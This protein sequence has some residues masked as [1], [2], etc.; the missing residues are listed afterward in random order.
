MAKIRNTLAV[1]VLSLVLLI[2]PQQNTL[3]MRL[4]TTYQEAVDRTRRL[5][6]MRD[7]D[8]ILVTFPKSGTH[9]LAH[10]VTELFRNT[11]KRYIDEQLK[12]LPKGDAP[13]EFFHSYPIF[14]LLPDGRARP[15]PRSAYEFAESVPQDITRIFL[16]RDWSPRHTCMHA[17]RRMPI[18]TRISNALL[19]L[20]F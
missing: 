1:V 6:K 11:T 15:V 14:T 18:T 19:F 20:I 7:S 13:V 17:L 5:T 4:T 16:V 3:G 2:L 12:T 8:I 9:F 10:A